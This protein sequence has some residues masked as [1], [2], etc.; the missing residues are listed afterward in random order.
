MNTL[1]EE[2]K[3]VL[4]KFPIENTEYGNMLFIPSD[5]PLGKILVVGMNPSEG[6]KTEQDNIPFKS[7]KG[8]HWNPIINVIGDKLIDDSAYLDLFPLRKTDQLEFEKLG[9]NFRGRILE[10]TQREIERIQPKLIIHLNASSRYYWGP[11]GWMGYSLEET[12]FP[13]VCGKKL[14]KITGFN[15]ACKDRINP[16]IME[17][18]LVGSYIFFYRMLSSKYEAGL[19]EDIK[20][21]T[22][23]ISTMWNYVINNQ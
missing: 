18:K 10:V 23:D 21:N 22:N 16:E 11:K 17:S 15:P 6:D 8:K 13:L 9:N 12:N 20:L 19:S 5:N 7:F 3:K 4:I 14:Y 1:L 2:Y